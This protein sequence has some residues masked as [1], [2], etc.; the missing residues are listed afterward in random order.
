MEFAGEFETHLTVR[1][2]G[3]QSM[4]A[5][6]AWAVRNGLKC[7]HIVLERGRTPSQPMLN[8]RG[9]GAFSSEL[10][11]ASELSRR[12]NADGFVVSRLKIEATPWNLDV[13][14]SDR[15]ASAHH[16]ERYFEHHVKLALDP[17]AATAALI[18]LAQGH[19]A[20]LSRNA[21]RIRDDGRHERF[22]TQRCPAVGRSTA[23]R[24]LH[25]LLEALAAG[26]YQVLDV[27]EEFVVYDSNTALDAGWIEP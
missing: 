19:S 12:L 6:Q 27:E 10:A 1:L 26:G 9:H 11:T 22:V 3:A 23:C 20:H 18:E 4:E 16:R 13:P 7:I 15:E 2:D 17:S 24:Q 5:L 25:D 14:E 21:M 8:R